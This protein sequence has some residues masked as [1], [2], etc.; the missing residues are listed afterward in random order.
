M[1]SSLLA[2]S[3][4][5]ERRLHMD[6]GSA[7]TRITGRPAGDECAAHAFHSGRPCQWR[8]FESVCVTVLWGA[9]SGP[10][11]L[12]EE[13][14]LYTGPP[15]L[16]TVDTH[17]AAVVRFS[18]HG[19]HESG[20]S[21]LTLHPSG[22]R[23]LYEQITETL[24]REIADGTLPAGTR[25]PSSRQLAHDLHV[26]RITVVTAYAEL[27]AAGAIESRGGSGTYVLPPWTPPRP[28]GRSGEARPSPLGARAAA[29][30]ARSRASGQRG[31][32]GD[33]RPRA[34]RPADARY[35]RVRLGRGRSSPHSHD[36]VSPRAR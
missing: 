23:P 8:R 33:P 3:G 17:P 2:C 20:R 5:N 14:D 12:T 7:L 31:T 19:P 28:A 30:A 6:A 24:Q 26:S 18:R 21:M 16:H 22:T 10:I 34:A 1:Y 9:A 15:V 29:L 32:G 11:V 25:L 4:C 35:D 27:E 13:L 36:R